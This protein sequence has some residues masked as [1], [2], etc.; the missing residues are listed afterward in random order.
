M[1]RAKLTRFCMPPESSD[2]YL[3]SMPDKPTSS[4]FS[5]T[6]FS[7]SF[8]VYLPRKSF[9]S[10]NAKD[11]LSKTFKESKSA[12]Y[13]NTIAISPPV[14]IIS[15]ESFSINP[16]ISFNTVLFPEPLKPII[17]NIFPSST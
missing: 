16:L 4:S 15:P 12:E 2:G 10:C 13:W 14:V 5:A 8:R 1:A 9:L 7:N 6:I 3:S 17:D 11:I